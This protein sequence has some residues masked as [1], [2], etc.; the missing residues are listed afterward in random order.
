[1]R[2]AT[3]AWRA[4]GANALLPGPHLV[5]AR[6]GPSIPMS[7]VAHVASGLY[8]REYIDG[9]A[10]GAAPYLRVDNVRAFVPN[11]SD[12]DVVF[13]NADLVSSYERVSV[14]A[15]DVVIPRT[16]LCPEPGDVLNFER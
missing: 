7:E 12:G 6:L 8:V 2:S 3:V 10:P 4:I 15:G 9:R 13:V 11:L 14:Q 1:M 16:S 5:A